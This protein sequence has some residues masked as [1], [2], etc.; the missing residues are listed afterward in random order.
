M[1][2]NQK[3][4][5]IVGG[6]A[7]EH[8]ITLKLLNDINC[9]EI[10]VAPGNP[11]ILL[12]DP[13]RVKLLN[14]EATRVDL[15]VD[16]SIKNKPDLVI[17]GPENPLNCGLVDELH[18]S[19]V[20]SFG[21][22][23]SAAE[24]E[25]N[26][27]FAKDFM[28]RNHIKTAKY[29]SF[30]DSTLA[31]EYIDSESGFKDGYVIKAS[32][33]ASGK[34][35]EIAFNKN[36][37]KT[38]VKSFIDQKQFGSASEVIVVEEYIVGEECSVMAFSDGF[39]V[40]IMPVAQDH[41]K[42]YDND[43][44]PMTGGM[45]AICPYDLVESNGKLK[46]SIEEGVIKR[47]I[48]GLAKEGRKF[49]GVLFAG[50]MIAPNNEDVF[51]L[52][53]NCRFG[54]PETQSILPLITFKDVVEQKPQPF[55]RFLEAC[56]DG[57][58]NNYSIDYCTN[59]K[60]VGVV[61]ADKNYPMSVKKNQLIQGLPEPTSPE[62]YSN[63]SSYINSSYIIHAGTKFGDNS[64]QTILTNGGR[65]LTIV[66]IGKSILE[67]QQAALAKVSDI[68]IDQSRFRSDIGFHTI[69][70]EKS[71]FTQKLTYRESGVDI[72]K[73]EEFV[74]FV[75]KVVKRTNNPGTI[76]SIGAFAALFDLK[77]TNL[78]DPI[79]VS[80]TDGVGTKLKLA[81][82][83]NN[84][85]TI[86]QDLVAMCVNDVLVHGALP[87]FFLD[88]YA[89]RS[90]NLPIAKNVLQGIVDGCQI[91]GCSLIGGETAEL[92]DI[93]RGNDIDLAGFAVGAVERDSML[94][95]S[96]A[97]DEGDVVLGLSSSGIHSNGF[98]LV[99]NFLKVNQ[100]SLD[101]IC[102]FETNNGSQQSIGDYLLTPTK[103]YAN[104]VG[105]VL[106]LQ[107]ASMSK[108]PIKAMAHITGG[109][110]IDNISRAIPSGFCAKLDADC[111]PIHPVFGWI[112]RDGPVSVS[113]MLKV[114]NL[115]I[116]MI[117]IVAERH[118]QK[119]IDLL[120][121]SPELDNE[122]AQ[123]YRIGKIITGNTDKCAVDNLGKALNVSVAC[124]KDASTTVHKL[125][126]R[127]R[128][129]ILL[130]GTGTNARSLIEHSLRFPSS[131]YHVSLVVSNKKEAPGLD[132][133]KQSNI[134]T[135]VCSKKSSEE[136]IVYDQRLSQILIDNNIQ[137]VCLA[138]FMHILSKEFVDKWAGKLINIHPSLLPSF[139]GMHAYKQALD[140]RVRFTGCTIH[141]V[142][143]GVDEGAIIAQQ[144]I[145]VFSNDT[146]TT[147]QER[148]KL[149]EHQ[150]YPKA[151]EL[152]SGGQVVYDWERNISIFLNETTQH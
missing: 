58:L 127:K 117:L 81:L 55:G 138:G 152:V 23:K 103:I 4:Y 140:A 87:L 80:G 30:S 89:C 96:T 37:A 92:S 33:L 42:A 43:I 84:M 27:Q 7:R 38:A 5:L 11:G 146:E 75:K 29:K 26:K 59:C 20:K 21:P 36:D 144:P 111:W 115:G 1:S 12:S 17:I 95:R 114:F 2:E 41:K 46:K 68:N 116:G 61:I 148:G 74:D 94:P 39:D 16:W 56:V 83:M 139:K 24:I 86:G 82:N 121:L 106:K 134:P 76:P 8:A 101:S 13:N 34:G 88:Y 19:G 91:A 79:L 78:R 93:Y 67:A 143:S 53:Y 32:G 131:T 25:C 118:S 128:V 60:L 49:V 51:V 130:S 71:V 63:P 147:L 99:R 97:I 150:L 72:E 69:L 149:I 142:N 10:H 52:E 62:Q 120:K 48:D 40:E 119:V 44:G 77:K 18:K 109:G 137:V 28:V 102:P 9:T 104:Q 126:R 64:N 35:V 122:N 22:T 54:D 112:M 108:H 50:L 136:R 129:A 145:E 47:C 98:S 141:F 135:I 66:G 14:I 123:V 73:G 15:I 45:G 151:L 133:A 70:R 31:C 3:R 124:I 105:R 113:E 107:D 100:I 90:I 57:T 125:S 132:F 6:G 110:L 85:T 65:I